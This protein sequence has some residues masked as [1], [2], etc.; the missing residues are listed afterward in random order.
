MRVNHKILISFLLTA[1]MLLSAC[2]VPKETSTA[3]PFAETIEDIYAEESKESKTEENQKPEVNDNEGGINGRMVLEDG[4]AFYICGGNQ[5]TKVDKDSM[6]T[7]L[8]WKSNKDVDSLY[9]YM[10]GCNEALLLFG[11]IYFLEEY[12]SENTTRYALSV[13]DCDGRNYRQL[14][15]LSGFAGSLYY[16]NHR[17]YVSGYDVQ[18]VFKLLEDGSVTRL[19]RQ[20]TVYAKLPENY[21]EPRHKRGRVLTVAE[22]YEKYGYYLLENEEYH[23][24]KV[25]P[26]TLKEEELELLGFSFANEESF[27]VEEYGDEVKSLYLIDAK[28]LSS[29]DLQKE[30]LGEYLMNVTILDMDERY[31]YLQIPSL[32]DFG[33][34]SYSYAKLSLETGEQSDIFVQSAIEGISYSAVP[35]TNY[36]NFQA[37]DGYVYFADEREEQLYLARRSVEMP[38]NYEVLGDAFYDSGIAQVGWLEKTYQAHYSQVQPE[39]AL[40]EL[41]A[42]TLKVDSKFPGADKIN[43]YLTEG[44]DTLISSSEN[45]EE[46]MAWLEET[47]AENGYA[48][49]YE[50]YSVPSQIYYFDG[51]YFSFYQK[52]YISEGG[53]HG[54]PVQEG[55][56]FHLQTGER[57]FLKDIVADSEERIKKI[58]TSYF[59]EYMR[60]R[61]NEFWD[62]ALEIVNEYSG[63]DSAFYLTNEGIVFYLYP[64]DIAPYAFGFPTVEIPYSEFDMK[65]KVSS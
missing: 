46:D 32:S 56:T 20:D 7:E 13:I 29:D 37:V 38:E 15:T 44:L 31:V 53:A 3:N 5:I 22:S 1:G 65:I 2:G 21:A 28:N 36:V 47:L 45:S 60:G 42:Y 55:Y 30:F 51:T 27:L 34:V 49:A 8:L 54:F 6:E 58:V 14:V 48:I 9:L 43:E 12:E 61:E 19:R 33:E 18:E 35:G 40:S 17:L 57:L 10:D 4:Y 52:E 24:V 63:L 41:S 62:G 16:S 25:D 50:Y 59:A 23:L 64:Y 39:V 11:K 26:E